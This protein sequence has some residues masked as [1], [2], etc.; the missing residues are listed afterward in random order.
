VER[1]DGGAVAP[2]RHSAVKRA[3]VVAALAALVA[4]VP[5]GAMPTW[6]TPQP[7]SGAN[8]DGLALGP[9]LVANASGGAI[10]VWDRETGPDCATA[11]ASLTCIHTVEA[12]SRSGA[13]APWEAPQPINRPGVG[14]RPQAAIDDAGDAALLWVHDI[15]R[16]RVVQASLRRGPTG[17]FSAAEDISKEVLEVRSHQIALDAAGDAAAVWA[18]RPGD[19][20]EVR[21]AVRPANGFW[22]SA[23]LLSGAG[24]TGGPSMAV[25]PAGEILVVWSELGVVRTARGDIR[26]GAWDSPVTLSNPSGE[27]LG[28]PSIATNARGDAVAIWQWRDRPTGQA[29]VQAAPRSAG[30]SWGP[31]TDVGNGGGNGAPQVAADGSGAAVAVWIEVAPGGTPLRS[32]VRAPGAAW[33]KPATVTLRNAADPRLGI[34]PAGNAVVVW[35]DLDLPD[36][37]AAV[38]PEAA[39]AWQPEAILSG[40]GA[41]TLSV[42]VDASG[43]AVAVWERSAPPRLDVESADLAGGWELTLANTSRPS[44]QGRPRVG[45][46]LACRR[47]T[48]D[49][50]VPIRYA[51]AWSRD[52][53]VVQ[54]ARGAVYTVRRADRGRLLACRVTAT[55]AARSLAATSRAVRVR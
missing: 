53:R 23:R 33:S 30:A 3:L 49:G 35:T 2:G 37:R 41:A 48:W 47:G 50:T 24:V 29:I 25:T 18:Q 19:T 36:A 42:A 38:L 1:V 21:A 28:E 22:G 45:R 39:G 32:S 12:V 44:I 46:R 14:A 7:I 4:V 43:R 5:G 54:G 15:G 13:G 55:N 40:A 26:T 11:P 16:D 17:A 27:A 20:F 10:A 9:E 52:R 8:A 31:A 34:D 51:Y 6:S